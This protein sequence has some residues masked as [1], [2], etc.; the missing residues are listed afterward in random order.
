MDNLIDKLSDE[1]LKAHRFDRAGKVHDWRNYIGERTRTHW[2]E[3]TSE[4][5]RAL[6]ADAEDMAGL[7]DWY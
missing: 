6:A 2:L 3:F 7:E 1:E 4:Q 5:R